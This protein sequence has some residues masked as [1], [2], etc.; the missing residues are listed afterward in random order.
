M[1]V[2]WYY[3]W[4]ARPPICDGVEVVPML[5]GAGYVGE[6]LGGNSEWLMG[7]N[8]PDLE[9]QANISPTKAARLWKEIEL[10]YP[11]K[12]VS[13]SVLS[14]SWLTSWYNEYLRI[15][16]TS[17][18]IDAVGIH[19]YAA[20]NPSHSI[21]QCKELSREAM[22]WATDRNISEVWVTEYAYLP[23]LKG[24]VQGSIDFMVA[25]REYFDSEP[26]ITR[27]AWFQLSYKGDEPWAWGPSCNTSLVD[28]YSGELTVLGEAY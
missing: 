17:P 1:N 23:C 7:F 10:L 15:Y 18:R 9:Y 25:M 28:F 16:G 3:N 6:S 19:C 8:E 12:L 26:M 14:I 20:L 11:R 4:S 5:W 2:K 22:Q 27:D 24:G 13:P 21:Y